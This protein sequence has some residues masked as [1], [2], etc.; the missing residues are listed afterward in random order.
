MDSGLEKERMRRWVLALGD[1]AVKSCPDVA[2]SE[3]DLGMS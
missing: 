1:E 2:L 3:D